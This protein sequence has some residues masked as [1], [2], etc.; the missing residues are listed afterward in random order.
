MCKAR[1]RHILKV[2]S[3]LAMLG[4]HVF[5]EPKCFIVI[6]DGSS[7]VG[8]CQSPVLGACAMRWTSPL[9]G[10]S[11]CGITWGWRPAQA[12][13]PGSFSAFCLLCMSHLLLSFSSPAMKLNH[14]PVCALTLFTAP[15]VQ[16]CTDV[17][18]VQAGEILCAS[19]STSP[20]SLGISESTGDMSPSFAEQERRAN[21]SVWDWLCTLH[22]LIE[23]L[24]RKRW[25]LKNVHNLNNSCSELVYFVL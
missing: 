24:Q 8:F 5:C 14:V 16:A 7:Q 1:V 18:A 4:F 22:L 3:W 13:D 2:R 23:I 21:K 20:T 25:I 10:D 9:A 6:L 15:T 12:V 17:H 19:A 11:Q